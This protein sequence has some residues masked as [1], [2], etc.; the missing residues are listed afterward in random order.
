MPSVSLGS[1]IIVL[2]LCLQSSEKLS[3]NANKLKGN[4]ELRMLV[5]QCVLKSYNDEER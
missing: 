4:V 2:H 5:Y 3:K 1:T